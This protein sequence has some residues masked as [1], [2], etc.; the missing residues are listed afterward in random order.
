MS[1]ITTQQTKLDLELIL[2]RKGL[3]LE[4]AM[5]DLILERNKESLHFKLSW[6]LLLLLHAILHF[7]SLQ[8]FLKC[9]CTNSGILSTNMKIP[10]GSEWTR[11][12][13]ST[14]IGKSS[15]T[16]FRS[17]LEF[18]VKTLM[19]FQLMKILCLSSKNLVILEKSNQSSMLLLT[20]CINLGELLP[21]SS[22]EVY[23]E[24]QLV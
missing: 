16:S 21:L 7:S 4:N 3:R 15:K 19:H 23:L 18:M 9:T 24:R 13:N 11:K 1:S 20:R 8:M 14:S 5:E 12:R 10:T 17:A 22:T 6:M 2:K